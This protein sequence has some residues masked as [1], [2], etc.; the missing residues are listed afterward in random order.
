MLPT[1]DLIY[2]LPDKGYLLLSSHALQQLNGYAQLAPDQPESG[3][4]LI[5]KIR[6][7][8][9]EITFAT[10]PVTADVQSRY[11]FIRKDPQHLSLM[12]SRWEQSGFTETYLG[13]WHTHPEN[14][15]YPSVIDIQEWKQKLPGKGRKEIMMIV[16][17]ESIW[18]GSWDG[19]QIHTMKPQTV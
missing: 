6:P 9:I 16:G 2:S 8:H 15:P 14:I 5:G 10:T 3:G 1:E 4:I 11:R 18:V 7:P 19:M 17:R 12:R 13:E